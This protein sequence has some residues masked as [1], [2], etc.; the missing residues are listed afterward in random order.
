M[1]T[2][3]RPRTGANRRGVRDTSG[4]AVD[5]FAALLAQVQAIY[6]IGSGSVFEADYYSADGGT[7]KV[8]SFIDRNDAAHALA[9]A[10]GSEQVAIPT[11]E[12]LVNGALVGSFLGGQSYVSNRAA[13]TFAYLHDG[14]GAD[15]TIGLIHRDA[16]TLA[17]PNRL[18]GTRTTTTTPVGM[19]L[20]ITS[21]NGVTEERVLTQVYAAA[22]AVIAN[23]GTA[24]LINKDV[25]TYLQYKYKE[26]DSPEWAQYTK[27]TVSHSGAS[28]STPPLGG[29]PQHTLRLGDTSVAGRDATMD[30]FFL[31]LRPS[32]LTGAERLVV[33][34]YLLLKY[35][36]T[37]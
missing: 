30:W 24:G 15:L 25:P 6:A 28:S 13:S 8:A 7:G 16:N 5:P 11:T 2:R 18:I 26:G 19:S 35:G 22:T 12:A 1:I 9:Q 17:N 34:A 33:Q 20:E 27:G 14:S 37:A 3:V 4:A 23:T 10:A 29:A 21:Q 31:A 32:P 36:I